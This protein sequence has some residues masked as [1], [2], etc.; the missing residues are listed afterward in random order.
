M[1][2]ATGLALV[3][4]KTNLEVGMN[5]VFTGRPESVRVR[6]LKGFYAR[7]DG[8]HKVVNPNDVVEIPYELACELKAA[9]KVIATE[10][11]VRIANSYMPERKKGGPVRDAASVQL[12]ALTAAVAA[13]QKTVD[14]SMQHRGK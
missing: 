4:A 7:V 1:L 8:V 12:E 10:E 5:K 2:A 9:N 3:A 11:A 6:S 14:Y 13:L